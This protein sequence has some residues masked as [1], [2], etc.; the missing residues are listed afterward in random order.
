M[1]NAHLEAVK[2]LKQKLAESNEDWLYARQ[3]DDR[4]QGIPSPSTI[5]KQAIIN[6]VIELILTAADGEKLGDA[7]VRTT[8]SNESYYYIFALT[9]TSVLVTDPFRLDELNPPRI[10]IIPRAS[11]TKLT[12]TE[13]FHDQPDRSPQSGRGQLAIRAEWRDAGPVDLLEEVDHGSSIF[14]NVLDE[15]RSDLRSPGKQ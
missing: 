11:I 8:S 6:R 2:A 3:E 4:R 13:T 10:Q 14:R 5:E 12:L 15:L 1:T 7:L 9:S